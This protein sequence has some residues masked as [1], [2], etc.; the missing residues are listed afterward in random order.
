MFSPR[1]KRGPAKRATRDT[2]LE[3]LSSAAVAAGAATNGE[4]ASSSIKRSRVGSVSE[5]TNPSRKHQGD[6]SGG[7]TSKRSGRQEGDA[8]GDANSPVP[9]STFVT[10]DSDLAVLVQLQREQLT[11]FRQQTADNQRFQAQLM[12]MLAVLVGQLAPG[13]ANDSTVNAVPQNIADRT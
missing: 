1:R 9:A 5:N 8:G 10:T 13:S 3:T 11:L 12:T 2:A 7:A 6:S 4:N